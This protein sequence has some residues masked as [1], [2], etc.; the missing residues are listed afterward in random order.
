MRV[1][2]WRSFAICCSRIALLSLL[3]IRGASGSDVPDF[4]GVWVEIKPASGPP[5]RL[6]VTQSGSR[7]Q[8]WL[9]YFEGFPD[10]PWGVAQIEKGSAIFAR[11]QACNPPF[12]WDGYNYDNPGLNTFT[13]SLRQPTGPGDLSPLLVYLQEPIG[14]CL[15]PLT[16]RSAGSGVRGSLSGGEYR[17]IQNRTQVG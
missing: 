17:Y 10:P 9:S 1:L 4:A 13:L 5:A 14:T 6:K 2:S 3:L 16:I 15:V 7:L 8:I 12:R 11:P